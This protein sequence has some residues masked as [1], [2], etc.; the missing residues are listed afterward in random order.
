MLFV[1]LEDKDDEICNFCEKDA[2]YRISDKSNGKSE[3]IF[4][5]EEHIEKSFTKIREDKE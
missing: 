5:C 1:P 2:L 4:T 3:S